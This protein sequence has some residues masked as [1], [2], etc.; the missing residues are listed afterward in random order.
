MNTWI[1]RSNWNIW[2]YVKRLVFRKFAE[3]GLKLY[4]QRVPSQVFH[5][6]KG[7]TFHSFLRVY[8]AT[9]WNNFTWLLLYIALHKRKTASQQTIACSRSTIQKIDKLWNVYKVYN[10]DSGVRSTN[11]ALML[12]RCFSS[13]SILDFEFYYWLL[14]TGKC[15]MGGR[16]DN[17]RW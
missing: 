16:L 5:R 8:T 13:V 1:W 6:D 2:K 4:Y 3:F 10:K 7:Y 14:S 17:S 12:C 15:P 11:V 9:F